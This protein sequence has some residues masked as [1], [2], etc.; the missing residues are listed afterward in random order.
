MT[1]SFLSNPQNTINITKAERPLPEVRAI[2][3]RMMIDHSCATY[4]ECIPQS[5]FDFVS[6]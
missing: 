4:F 5:L 1:F 3:A 2:F 6:K